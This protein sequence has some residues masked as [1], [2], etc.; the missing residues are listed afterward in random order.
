MQV[1]GGRLKG[2]RLLYPRT[3][4]R[5]TKGI[6]RQAI[7][8]ILG[9]KVVGARVCDL[10]A[11]G[12]ALGIEA[13]SRGAREVVFIEKS[14]E[15]VHFIK[16]NL[17][18]LEGCRV[19]KGDVCR[20]LSKMSN[21]QFDIILADPPYEKGLVAKTLELIIKNRLVALG[22][23]LVMEHSKKEPPATPEVWEKFQ[24]RRYGESVVTFFRRWK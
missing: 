10:F 8:N 11:G 2:R 15:A 20:V 9:E 19:I 17:K 3:E 23:I 13:L 7:F 24:Q 1:T 5:P 14:P 12:G 4:I 21:K 16:E 18:G 22:G 6:T